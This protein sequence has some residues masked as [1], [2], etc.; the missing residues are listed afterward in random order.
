MRARRYLRVVHDQK[1]ASRWPHQVWHLSVRH[2]KAGRRAR[3]AC[4]QS[5]TLDKDADVSGGARDGG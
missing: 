5:A 2:L 4:R 1:C 3:D